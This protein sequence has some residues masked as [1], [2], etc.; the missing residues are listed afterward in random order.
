VLKTVEETG[1]IIS[2]CLRMNLI[3][4]GERPAITL[5]AGGVS[6]LIARVDTARGPICVKR[7][8]PKLK[9]AREWLA[10]IERNSAEV[11]FMKFA[12]TVAPDFVPPVLGED[13]TG[14]AFAMA[15]LPSEQ[16]PV[17]KAQLRDGIVET[18]TARAVASALARVHAATADRKDIARA[19]ANDAT[20]YAIRLEPYFAATAGVH[21]DVARPLERLIETTANTRLALVH[22]DVSPKNILV[23]ARGP[24]LL[25]AECAWYG[26]PAFD[27]AFCLTHLLLKCLWR[28]LFAMRYLSCF[29]AFVSTY[30]CGLTWEAAAALEARTCHLL[31]GMLLARIDG[32]SPVEYLDAET[33]RARVRAFAKR[34]LLE[35]ATQ[36]AAM[37]AAWADA[38]QR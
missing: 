28:P 5:L 21:P 34:F 15:Y 16:Y 20:F 38:A 26:D 3:A 8:L 9:V 23:G 1:D 19:F 29:D 17:W 18:A 7:A 32:K 22:G 35:P 13:P 12:A 11:A 27:V 33:E 14:K 6:S 4:P 36:L 10:P 37:R 31:A 25:D 2:A 30:R 24:V